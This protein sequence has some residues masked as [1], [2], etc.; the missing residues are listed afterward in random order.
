MIE[1]EG[2]INYWRSIHN[3]VDEE[4]KNLEGITLVL[5]N[6]MEFT[7]CIDFFNKI[8]SNHFTNVLYISLTRSYDYMRHALEQNP[9]DQKQIFVIDCVSGFAFP[10]EENIDNCL[11]HK[12]PRDLQTMKDIIHFGIDKT[13]PDIIIIDSLSQLIN[14]SKPTEQELNGFYTFLGHMRHQMLN[15]VNNTFILLFDTKMGALHHLP[16]QGIDTILKLEI[17]TPMRNHHQ[18]VFQKGPDHIRG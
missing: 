1:K 2:E 16:T 5:H 13:N 7:Q 18:E 10:A 12:P 8:K 14:F 15:I 4:L 9:L 3:E 6:S 11:Y 17:N